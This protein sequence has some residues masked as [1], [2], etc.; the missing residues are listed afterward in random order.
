ML[1]TCSRYLAGMDGATRNSADMARRYAGA[2]L[3]EGDG[4]RERR[5]WLKRWQG[6]I[7][8][9][10]LQGMDGL[11]LDEAFYSWNVKVRRSMC[12]KRCY[13]ERRYQPVRSNGLRTI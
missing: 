10:Y 6:C 1:T 3:V 9:F 7:A 11:G 4:V 2:T 8:A 13:Q 12:A 5:P